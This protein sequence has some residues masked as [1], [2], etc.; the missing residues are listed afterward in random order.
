[1]NACARLAAAPDGYTI[2]FAS[3]SPM[4][5]NPNVVTK[6][7]ALAVTSKQRVQIAPELPTV[8]EAALPGFESTQWWGAYGPAGMPAEI[9][10]KLN[11]DIGKVLGS[12]EV[13]QRLAADAAEPAGGSPRDLVEYLKADFEKWG[14]VVREAKIRAD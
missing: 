8:A 13:K 7:R 6:L 14:K 1:M 4:V 5:I 11:A 12:A 2:L 10:A 9:V 3:S